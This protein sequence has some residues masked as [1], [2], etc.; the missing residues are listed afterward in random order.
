MSRTTHNLG[1]HLSTCAPPRP[2]STRVSRAPGTPTVAR[3]HFRQP[4]LAHAAGSAARSTTTRAA[5][6]TPRRGH[7]AAHTA[8]GPT[9]LQTLGASTGISAV[10]LHGCHGVEQREFDS[11]FIWSHPPRQHT[12]ASSSRLPSSTRKVVIGVG[13]AATNWRQTNASSHIVER[14]GFARRGQC[15]AGSRLLGSPRFQPS[16]R[17]QTSTCSQ[18]SM[19]LP[20]SSRAPRIPAPPASAPMHESNGWA[21]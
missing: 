11:D 13:V 4:H 9:F 8:F 14:R 10:M 17:S 19:G 5:R 3:R 2:R 16:T 12:Q 1:A 6:S 21:Y 18:P 7:E 15:S 20:S